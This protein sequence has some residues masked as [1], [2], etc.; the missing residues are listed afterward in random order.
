MCDLRGQRRA[1]GE[2]GQASHSAAKTGDLVQ[3]SHQNRRVVEREAL[4][5]A[6]PLQRGSGQRHQGSNIRAGRGVG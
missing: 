1:G 3:C 4:N 5:K 6:F 2:G